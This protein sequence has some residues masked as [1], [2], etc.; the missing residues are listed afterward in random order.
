MKINILGVKID[1]LTKRQVAKEIEEYLETEKTRYIVTPYSEFIVKA[2]DDQSFREILNSAD[3]AVPDGMGI[4]WAGGILYESRLDNLGLLS[5]IF[6]IIFGGLLIMLLPKRFKSIFPEKIS[7]AD[8]IWNIS[9]IA[10]NNN[11]TI[12]LLGGWDNTPGKAAAAL[13]SRYPN[14][15]IVGTYAGSPEPSEEKDI[16]EIVKKTKPDILLVAF[17]PV[18]QEKWIARN[19]VKMP[20]L[21]LAAGLGGT[22][23]YLAKKRILAPTFLRER[24]LEWLF[25]LFTQPQRIGRI[26]KAIPKFAYL[27]IKEGLKK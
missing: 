9:E 24:G 11:K 19:I 7:G 10:E 26:G 17:G 2:R 15:N 21:K 4:I 27:V 6:K 18:K 5:K 8:L 22:F 3:I 13:K 25:R 14:L 23:D 16:L 12:F 1:N 20:F